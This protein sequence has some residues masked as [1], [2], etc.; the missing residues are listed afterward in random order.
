VPQ[1]F[2]TRLA[3]VLVKLEAAKQCSKKRK[4]NST[5]NKDSASNTFSPSQAKAKSEV[6]EERPC[7]Q[8]RKPNIRVSSA[9]KIT[10]MA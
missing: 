9:V 4:D 1:E 2:V 10:Q 3:F 8:R 6:T 5:D 7:S